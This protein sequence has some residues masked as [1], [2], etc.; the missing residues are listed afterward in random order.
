MEASD[1]EPIEPGPQASR[2]QT[3][4]PGQG[5]H[6]ARSLPGS[7]KFIRPAA[8]GFL[9]SASASNVLPPAKGF[10]IAQRRASSAAYP[11]FPDHA[12]PGSAFS[13]NQASQLP[14]L[15]PRLPSILPVPLAS[16]SVHKSPTNLANA[17]CYSKS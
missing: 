3:G 12:P 5:Q 10:K 1:S 9:A 7:K 6:T 15:K 11:V 17:A 13:T 4:L 2:F 8:S 16:V 14:A